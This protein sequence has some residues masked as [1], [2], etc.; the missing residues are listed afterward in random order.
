MFIRR[1]IYYPTTGFRSAFEELDRMR[2]DMDRLFGGSGGRY[3]TPQSA[4]VFPLINLTEDKDSYYVRAE[5][6]GLKADELNIS[7][8][9][10]T[11]AITGERKVADEGK[12][13]RYHRKEREAGTFSRIIS[14]PGE[15][16]S[17]KVEAGLNNGILTV[18]I[19]KA[20]AA[21]PRQIT[22][23]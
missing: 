12:N 14:L 17:D 13:V 3:P 10:N 5:L 9:G 15:V 21:K 11:L 19:P 16:N 20:E 22:V 1:P 18:H 4:G 7:A 6:P 2:Q 8:T 23:K